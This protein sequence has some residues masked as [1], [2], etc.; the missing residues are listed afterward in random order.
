MAVIIS[1][2]ICRGLPVV[3]DV[4]L[5][6][7]PGATISRLKREIAANPWMLRGAKKIFLHVGTNDVDNGMHPEDVCEGLIRLRQYV[8]GLAPDA[9][10][11]I[12]GMLP[13][14]DNP[15][16]QE[17][18][19]EAGKLTRQKLRAAY[20]LPRRFTDK[21]HQIIPEYFDLECRRYP[22]LHLTPAG[23]DVLWA[24]ISNTIRH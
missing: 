24:T 2:S 9:K 16:V 22:G 23:K 14:L 6:P 20:I 11:Y 7:I 21:Y 18:V 4:G 17:R 5:Y 19:K 3:G 8:Q 12:S 10:V 1:D 15:Y 13:R